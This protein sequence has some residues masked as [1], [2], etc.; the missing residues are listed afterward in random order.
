MSTRVHQHKFDLLQES[1][2]LVTEVMA[3]RSYTSARAHV[4]RKNVT[5][6]IYKQRI[7]AVWSLV[8]YLFIVDDDEL[9]LSQHA[10]IMHYNVLVHMI[11]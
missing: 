3:C 5:K 7:P 2:A 8:S 10:C 1:E 6:T 9:S 4:L 11:T